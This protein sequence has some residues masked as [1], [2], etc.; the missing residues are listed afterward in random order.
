MGASSAMA[1]LT[2]ARNAAIPALG[3]VAIRGLINPGSDVMA[4]REASLLSA[5]ETP[6]TGR[7][8]HADSRG[9]TYLIARIGPTGLY[10]L[11]IISGPIVLTDPIDRVIQT[12]RIG[13]HGGNVQSAPSSVT[14][15][16]AKPITHARSSAPATR[17]AATRHR[18]SVTP[19]SVAAI[20]GLS[21]TVSRSVMITASH[22]ARSSAR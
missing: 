19:A 4:T 10:G 13:P 21:P 15:S 5:V 22:P 12:A 16:V 7:N 1:A 17:H 3:R 18:I 2:V 9:L 11:T 6:A 14:W 8:R 20:P